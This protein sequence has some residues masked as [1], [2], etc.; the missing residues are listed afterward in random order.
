MVR[1][2]AM[3]GICLVILA[4]PANGNPAPPDAVTGR[5]PLTLAA[6]SISPG[7][8]QAIS[9][10]ALAGGAIASATLLT[11]SALNRTSALPGA[12]L[13]GGT[14]VFTP[15][16]GRAI[17]GESS[18]AARLTLFRLLFGAS[19]AGAGAMAAHSAS[20]IPSGSSSAP[21][22][23]VMG[24]LGTVVLVHAIYDVATTR[25]DILLDRA[26]RSYTKPTAG[27]DRTI[28]EQPSL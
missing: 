12:I 4:L 26:V 24:V 8:A 20:S 21:G 6:E 25:R 1:V 9:V 13:S 11:L 7:G 2:T 22:Y 28:Y 10:I 3:A 27:I 17:A 16:L 19:A 5:R 15:S 14:L 23:A 18:S